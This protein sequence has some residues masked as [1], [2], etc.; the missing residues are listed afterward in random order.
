MA[1]FGLEDDQALQ[2]LAAMIHQ[3]DVGGEPVPE[4][5]GFEAVMAGARERLPDD[6]ALL[7]EMSVVLD[8]MYAHFQRQ[9]S[10]SKS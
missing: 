4:A 1:C 10:R 5:S 9:L 7:A 3:L 6:D 2:R 8:S